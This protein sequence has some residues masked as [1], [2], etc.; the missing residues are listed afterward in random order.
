MTSKLTVTN[1]VLNI[2]RGPNDS[3]AF[4]KQ[5]KVG[6]QYDVLQIIDGPRPPEQWAKVL[7]PDQQNINAY[8]CVTLPSGRPVS[9]VSSLP[10]QP[11][12]S[13]D[14]QRGFREGVEHVLRW[15]S[16]ERAKLG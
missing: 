2:R 9:K 10:A 6:E 12:E 15:L 16:A 3:A 11:G 4:I 7:L 1:P 5:A 8:M 13:A 14:F